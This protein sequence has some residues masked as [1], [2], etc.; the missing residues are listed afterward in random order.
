MIGSF[1]RKAMFTG[2]C[3]ATAAP[4][5]PY[6]LTSSGVTSSSITLNWEDATSTQ[7]YASSYEVGI[8]TGNNNWTSIT[9]N[10]PA[11]L[12]TFTSLSAGT[13]YHFRI[14]GVNCFGTGMEDGEAFT[15]ATAAGSSNIPAA[16]S[17]FTATSNF[18]DSVSLSWTDN[19][20]SPAEDGFD[21]EVSTNAGSSYSSVTTTAQNATSYSH[22]GRV[23]STAYLYRIRAT[24]TSGSSS[25]VTASSVTTPAA[26]QS[27]TATA[28]SSTQI[29]LSW[30][31]KS[32][33]ETG[34]R[35]ERST[36][37]T[38][39]SLVTT[40]AASA[41]SFSNTSLNASTLYYYRI[42]SN[43]YNGTN[44]SAWYT[45]NATTQAGTYEITYLVIAGGGGGGTGGGGAG[46]YRAGT[47]TLTPG[48]GAKTI[49]IGGGGVGG[50][51][52]ANGSD[53]VFDSVT[54]TGG[55]KGGQSNGGAGSS[56]GS[57]GGGG[58]SGN[59]GASSGGSG[60]SGQ[61]NAGG[62]NGGFFALPFP[63]GGGGGAGGAGGSATGNSSFGAGGSG[64]ASS[65]TGSSVTRAVGGSGGV[66][67]GGTDTNG[68]ANTGTGGTRA[69]S[70][71]S[72]V[73][74]L[75]MATANYSGTTTGS[76]SVTTSGSDTILTFNASG[77]YTA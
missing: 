41:T 24:N 48:S 9:I 14:R 54:S 69:G 26:V 50:T 12:Y 27:F 5:A 43:S 42:R 61:G 22:T 62:G 76:P 3:A 20:A 45:A 75:R 47:L 53:S 46:G 63:S 31:D 28:A 29:N 77:S 66:L 38:N 65:I 71:G 70:G 2:G 58:W 23:E 56:G 7:N 15:Q 51:S 72:G 35:I 74:I 30:T 6:D 34:F 73:V 11:S 19:S 17:G 16:P 60:T 67:V 18:A 8:S 25:W 40:T 64:S 10:A 49:T 37:N 32:G 68:S 1:M 21:I 4:D 55:G 52:N 57:G 36:D 13:T 39:W 44:D 59:P 33:V